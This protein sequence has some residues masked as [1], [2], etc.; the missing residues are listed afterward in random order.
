MDGSYV[1]IYEKMKHSIN[2]VISSVSDTIQVVADVADG[3]LSKLEEL[4]M[5]GRRGDDDILLPSLIRMLENVKM[6]VEETTSISNAAVEGSLNARGDA[7]K[8]NGEFKNVVSG[9][10]QTLE[11]IE[12]PVSEALSVLEQMAGGNLHAAV[13]GDYRG[14]YAA[15]KNA[16]NE[17]TSKSWH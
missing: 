2:N 12:K 13:K 4:K 6:L 15:I 11:A 5:I 14:D 17:T 16:L 3:N 8:F 9:I 10:N 1:G 7:G